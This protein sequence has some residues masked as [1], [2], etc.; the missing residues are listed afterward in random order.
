MTAKHRKNR[1]K[2]G[3]YCIHNR[4]TDKVYVGSASQL[5]MRC[6]THVFHLKRGHHHSIKL[7]RSWNKHG[8]E[9]FIF[10]VLEHCPVEKLVEREQYFID[11]MNACKNG[12]NIQPKAMSTQGLIKSPETIE[13]TRQGLIKLYRDFPELKERMS[14]RSTAWMAVPGN[15]EKLG[16][17]IKDAYARRTPEQREAHHQIRKQ[18][19]GRPEPREKLRK[20]KTGSK[21]SEE[22]KQK[23]SAMRLGRKAS[24][25]WCENIRTALIGHVVSPETREKIRTAN[26][27]W[28]PTEE[29]REKM[30]QAHIGRVYPKRGPCEANKGKKRTEESKA[31]MRASAKLRWMRVK[32]AKEASNAQ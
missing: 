7:Q 27:G 29:Q 13:K 1:G 8:E 20:I 31:K 14:V 32:E 16:A 25:E 15:K 28:K 11:S 6:R 5:R 30:R 19:M 17:A 23:L 18:A 10:V 24:P 21:A 22:T 3:I 9:A 26:K 2:S 12:Y 4:V